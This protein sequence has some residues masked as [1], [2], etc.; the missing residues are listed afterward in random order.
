VPAPG[1]SLLA[2]AALGAAGG[3]YFE[4]SWGWSALAFAWVAGLALVV[5]S[6]PRLGR[7]ELLFVGGL[8][9]FTLWVVASTLWVEAA[10]LPLREAERTV[11][12]VLAVLAALLVTRARFY[13]GLLGGAWAAISLIALYALGTKLLPDRFGEFNSLDEY[14]LSEPVGYWNALGILTVIG[15]LLALG[16]TARARNL[17]LRGLAAASTVV[18]L[19][20]L[21]LTLSRGAWVALGAGLLVCVALDSRRLQLVTTLLVLAPAPALGVFLAS[22]SDAL[23]VRGSTFGDATR[24]GHRLA[25]ILVLLAVAAAGAGVALRLLEQRIRIPPRARL[26]Y[27]AVLVLTAAALAVGTFAR[28]GGPV[29]LVERGYE[30]FV[31]PL[32]SQSAANPR[33]RLRTLSSPGRVDHW[34]I[35]LDLAREE[36]ILGSGAGTFERYWLQHRPNRG[37]VR[38]A[39]SLYLEVLAE[40]GP[41][42]LALLIGTLAVPLAVA[43]RARRRALVP[44]AAAAYVAYLVHAGVDWDWEMPVV[45]VAALLC[46]VGILAAGRTERV[47]PVSTHVRAALLAATVALGAFAFIGLMANYA[48]AESRNADENDDLRRAESQARRAIRW[49]PWSSEPWQ[50]LA[51]VHFDRN[52]LA[53]ARAALL[54]AVERDKG[55]WAIWFNLGVASTGQA[56]QRAYEEAARLNP[57]GGNINVLRTIGVLPKLPP[58]ES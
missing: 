19:P 47:R 44:A 40:L 3:G 2:V 7:A 45:T 54:E 20:A 53:K 26:A 16:L 21:Y 36:P 27:A 34:R 31:N 35:A 18:L 56:K 41:M 13:R 43:V 10:M 42:G 5:R 57:R 30:S 52:E 49:A 11:V 58:E 32:P 24:E 23:I 55:D 22:D 33:E 50:A 15:A 6:V 17:L 38:D 39:H 25:G 1:L 4:P 51:E 8:A 29:T 14:R 9:A 48:L 28:Y 37:V 46:A 12:Y